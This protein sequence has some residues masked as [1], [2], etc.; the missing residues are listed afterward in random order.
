MKIVLKIQ[1]S[2]KKAADAQV[3]Q[4]Q[5]A[6]M[7][8]QFPYL[9]IKT[10]LRR[11]LQKEAFALQSF[12][13]EEE[14]LDNVSALWELEEREYQYAAI[15]L[16]EKGRKLLTSKTL[17]FIEKFVRDKSW[18]DTVDFLAAHVTG[19]IIMKHP[20]LLNTMDL[21][22]VGD[23]FWIRRTAL[24]SQLKWKDKTDEERLF[25]YCTLTMH[26]KEFF[27]RKAIGW[28]LREYSK[29]N[30]DSVRQFIEANKT[31]LSGLSYREASKYV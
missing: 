21:W 5:R 25:R 22:V 10:T 18:W 2:F 19:N 17:P 30:P 3:A 1:D 7:K 24:L 26:E 9:G 16:L 29:T 23:S 27:I 14:L 20:V 31:K 12:E 6:Y 15:E 8:D 13:S 28:V 11:E 4:G